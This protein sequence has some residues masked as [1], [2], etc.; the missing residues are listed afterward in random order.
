MALEQLAISAQIPCGVTYGSLKLNPQ[1]DSLRG[2]PPFQKIVDSLAPKKV[3]VMPAQASADPE[4]RLVW[5]RLAL[6][7]L[8][9]CRI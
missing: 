2:D 3:D 4:S 6:S 5:M 1:W 8:F 7:Q 9:P